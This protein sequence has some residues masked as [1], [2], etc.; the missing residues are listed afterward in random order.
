M[1]QTL[2][3]ADEA[4]V[5]ATPD[6][7]S[8]RNAKNMIE[9]LSHGRPN[10][11]PPRL[12][13]NQVGVPGRPEISAKD[14]AEAVGVEPVLVLPFEPKLYGQAANNGQ[15]IGE[16]NAKSKSAEA[17]AGLARAIARR[18]TGAAP[19]AKPSALAG[20]FKRKS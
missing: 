15:M 6:L 7:T 8:L 11:G 16:L 5:V 18:E 14:F 3:S 9:L 4:V 2:L 13:L 20:L 1:R 17:I 19:E 12:V 10:D